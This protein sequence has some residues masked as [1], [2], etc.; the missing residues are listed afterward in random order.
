M[1]PPGMKIIG[2]LSSGLFE[3]ASFLMGLESLSMAMYDQPQMAATS[4]PRSAI[5]CLPQPN[6]WRPWTGLAHTGSTTISA[7]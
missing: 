6:D 1:L 7:I 5:R 4:L 2:G 3:H